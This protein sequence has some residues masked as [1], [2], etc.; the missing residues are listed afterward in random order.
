MNATLLEHEARRDALCQNLD[1]LPPLP[2]TVIGLA[3][4]PE[5]ERQFFSYLKEIVERDPTLLA[6][7]VASAAAIGE[8]L[9]FEID[10]EGLLQALGR[11]RIEGLII[12]ETMT[13]VLVPRSAAHRNLWLHSIQVA[14]A[15][16][17]IAT[18]CPGLGVKPGHAYL[19]GL[20]HDLGRFLMF[21]NTPNELACVEESDYQHPEEM[22][23]A[24][25][26]IFGMTHTAVGAIVCAEW[27]IHQD[28]SDAISR[29]HTPPNPE[30][31][32]PDVINLLSIL[33]QADGLSFYMMSDAAKA[34]PAAPLAELCQ[35]VDG[36]CEGRLW[37]KPP[38]SRDGLIKML[39]DV[40]I[41]STRKSRLA[42]G[43]VLNESRGAGRF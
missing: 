14:S 38:M 37:P 15:A 30:F 32:T 27:D 5:D 28:I 1:S 20:L 21:R 18:S 12:A 29:H 4:L 7:L 36:F 19:T 6:H 11:S 42:M 26:D 3:S 33:R 24:E 16:S 10:I 34:R 22:M 35:I 13:R 40:R 23:A 31:D 43:D 41:E 2:S 8:P 25:M 17:H 39:P 9:P